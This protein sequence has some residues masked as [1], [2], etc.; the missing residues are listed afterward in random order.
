MRVGSLCTCTDKN[1]IIEGEKLLYLKEML[2]K[3][4]N[5]QSI[6]VCKAEIE[7]QM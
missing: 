2:C 1:G 7:T 5:P 3:M 4:H 6:L